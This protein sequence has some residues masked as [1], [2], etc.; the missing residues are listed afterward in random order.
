MKS[1]T[2][3]EIVGLIQHQAMM[4]T[5]GLVLQEANGTRRFSILIGEPEAQ[6]ITL[7]LKNKVLPRPLTH[8][9]IIN[10]LQ[11]LNCELK[12][13]VISAL[14]ND[15][16][17]SEL[18]ITGS[19][20]KDYTVDARTSD[21]VAL[22]VRAECPLYIKSEILDQVGTELARKKEPVTLDEIADATPDDMRL[23]GEQTINR[24]LKQAVEE[25]K[26]EL[27]AKLKK[28]QEQKKQQ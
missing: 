16:F 7:K 3:L 12:E 23:L 21:A 9:L 14:K 4:N 13:V 8:D 26:Y 28:V 2:R 5:Y 10:I 1:E 22:A 15:I 18:H 25:E 17:Y 19:D 20:G 11:A 27:A 24:L 6:S